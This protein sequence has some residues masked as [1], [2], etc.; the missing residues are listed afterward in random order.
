MIINQFDAEK[1]ELLENLQGNILKGHGREH[2]ANL[3]INGINGNEKQLKKWLTLL[4]SSGKVQSCYAQLRDIQIW[5]NRKIDGGTFMCIHISHKG[6]IYLLG[7]DEAEKLGKSDALKKGMSNRDLKDDINLFESGL[8]IESDFMLIVANNDLE[9]LENELKIIDQE[10]TNIATIEFIQR[11]D[12]IKNEAGAGIEHFGYVD[13]I[14]QPVFFEDEFATYK[15]Q[16]GNPSTLT[17][18][19]SASV[20]LV[21]ENDPYIRDSSAF[22][23][24]LV[25]RKLEQDVHGFKKAEKELADRN[26]LD[27]DGEDA[28]RAGAMIV[29]RFED[30]TPVQLSAEAGLINNATVNNFD[31][32]PTDQSKCPYHAHIRKTN[33]RSDIGMKNSKSHIMA[34]R[35]IPYGIR[36]DNPNDGQFDNKPNG[37]VGLLFMSYQADIEKQFEF[38]QKSWANDETFLNRDPNENI[39]LDPIIGQGKSNTKGAY[40]QQWGK[41]KTMQNFSFEQFVTTR[42]GGYYFAPSIPFLKTL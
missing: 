42:G 39:G 19:P 21:L 32:N 27:L 41:P 10:L 34:R 2:T 5:K 35:G 28:E 3:F 14:S 31:Y 16:N 6:Y 7:K 18:D 36:L 29:G 30:G 23:S 4:A 20:N 26:H 9:T 25:F 37:G 8:S 38:I 11:G 22:G 33:P 13:G 40:A 12:A 1:R 24:Y 17:F 15:K